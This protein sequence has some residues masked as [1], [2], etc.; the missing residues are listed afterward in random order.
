MTVFAIHELEAKAARLRLH[1]SNSAEYAEALNAL[2]EAYFGQDASKSMQLSH[3]V[4]R[5]GVTLE[6]IALQAAS[7]WKIG[8]LSAIQGQTLDSLTQ[9][10]AAQLLAQNLA[11]LSLEAKIVYGLGTVHGVLGNYAEALQCRLS[12][13]DMAR[14]LGER[15]LEADCLDAIGT[16]YAEI[17]NHDQALSHYSASLSLYRTLNSPRQSTTLAHIAEACIGLQD[18]PQALHYGQL[19]LALSQKLKPELNAGPESAPD[20]NRYEAIILCVLGRVYLGTQDAER[21]LSYFEQALKFYEDGGF[22]I[23]SAMP[24]AHDYLVLQLEMGK[25]RMMLG[26]PEQAERIWM[27]ALTTAQHHAARPVEMQLH[28]LL[29]QLHRQA[30]QSQIALQH[31]EAWLALTQS[32]FSA[33]TD[34]RIKLLQV[35]HETKEAQHEASLLRL[36][37]TELE[38]IVQTRTRALEQAQIEMLERLAAAVEARD[39]P[40]GSHI[41]RVGMLAAALARQMGLDA[42]MVEMIRLAAPLHD[43]GKISI[44][45]DIL[46]KQEGLSEQ[47]AQIMRDHTVTGAK[48]LSQGTS[49]LIRMAETIALSHHEFWDG[50]GYPR[51]LAGEQIPLPG[52]IVA[53]A[54]AYDAMISERPYKLAYTLQTALGEIRR[55]AGTQFDPR[56]VDA[57]VELI[58]SQDSAGL[59][60]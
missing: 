18:Y 25:V 27:A 28:K 23:N 2:A 37:T 30:D 21:A 15:A 43:I 3:E 39:A 44:P 35:M 46:L 14:Q 19:A 24:G 9:L 54:D 4:Y 36:K 31:H 16:E 20:L 8:C 55:C 22:L 7:L 1:H 51:Q 41:K 48:M 59:F 52:R 17:G 58:E 5:L 53:V 45:D 38:Q 34:R 10:T 32:I 12:A 29:Y 33:E 57:L 6:H 50:S 11:D 26:A 42:E 49:Q 60:A 40:T 47:E 13:L 56:V